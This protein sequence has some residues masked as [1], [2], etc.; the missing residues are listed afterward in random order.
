MD[1]NNHRRHFISI[2]SCIDK[3]MELSYK[4]DVTIYFIVVGMSAVK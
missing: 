2:V 3:T 1:E 4:N